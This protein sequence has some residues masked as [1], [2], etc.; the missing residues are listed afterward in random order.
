[1]WVKVLECII[2]RLSIRSIQLFLIITKNSVCVG[3]M[4]WTETAVW[5]GSLNFS[6][7]GLQSAS[8]S[9]L[10]M[11]ICRSSKTLSTYSVKVWSELSGTNCSYSCVLC[12]R[13]NCAG[14]KFGKSVWDV[15]SVLF[16]RSS[17]D[18]VVKRV[19]SWQVGETLQPTAFQSFVVQTR[20][21]ENWIVEFV[22]LENHVTPT[23]RWNN[24]PTCHSSF[25]QSIVL[26]GL[27]FWTISWRGHS[28][29]LQSEQEVA[30]TGQEHNLLFAHSSSCWG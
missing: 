19:Y 22:D 8:P 9:L 11:L 24:M 6:L 28:D 25:S 12:C 30:A 10:Y 5:R 20:V 15:G 7:T 26:R 16:Q 13:Y 27:M 14:L 3:R 1:M 17:I 29:F 21:M 2:K 18:F 4:S 23:Q